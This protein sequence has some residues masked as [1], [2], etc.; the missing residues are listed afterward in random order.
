M[1]LVFL[2]KKCLFFDLLSA[3]V[4]ILFKVDDLLVM[5]YRRVGEVCIVLYSALLIVVSHPFLESFCESCISLLHDKNSLN[6][7]AQTQE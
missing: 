6:K 2:L 4:G 7:T 3:F 5:C 1:K